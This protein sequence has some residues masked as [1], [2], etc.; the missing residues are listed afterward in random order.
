MSCAVTNMDIAKLD[1][2]TAQIKPKPASQCRLLP[3]FLGDQCGEFPGK[4]AAIPA[5]NQLGEACFCHMLSLLQEQWRTKGKLGLCSLLS[6][7]AST[8][9]N[10]IIN[11]ELHG[12]PEHCGVSIL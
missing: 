2:F 8:L 1:P 9:V 12:E 5:L 7:K 6:L 11:S 10:Q 3:L 4:K